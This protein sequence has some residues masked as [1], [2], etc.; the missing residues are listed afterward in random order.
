MSKCLTFRAKLLKPRLILMALE[1]VLRWTP[2]FLPRMAM[3]DPGEALIFFFRDLRNS[4]VQILSFLGLS[5]FLLCVP[6]AVNLL[7][8]S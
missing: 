3:D 4:R 1:M 8:T 7:I 6:V 2:I 5:T